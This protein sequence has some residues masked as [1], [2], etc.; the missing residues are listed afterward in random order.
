VEVVSPKR[1]A[2]IKT[3]DRL[4]KS[5]CQQQGWQYLPDVFWLSYFGEC[6]DDPWLRG[7]T[8]NPKNPRWKQNLWVLI[9]EDRFAEIMDRA[10]VRMKDE[11][12]T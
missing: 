1:Q 2:R 10:I 3:A 4:A 6:A 8:P 12:N 9:R 5:L 11:S 7:D